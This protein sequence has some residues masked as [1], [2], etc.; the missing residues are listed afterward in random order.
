MAQGEIVVQHHHWLPHYFLEI[1][2][3]SFCWILI[4][5]PLNVFILS[6]IRSDRHNENFLLDLT[7]CH[8]IIQKKIYC[9]GIRGN[10][11]VCNSKI[12]VKKKLFD[13]LQLEQYASNTQNIS[14]ICLFFS[15][16]ATKH[17][18]VCSLFFL[19]SNISPFLWIYEFP[20][21]K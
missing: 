17:K 19:I 7:I 9:F 11:T 12:L 6:L 8:S 10:K 16:V 2:L 5:L 21:R 1:R 20:K 3:F 4:H 14:F 13:Q 18:I 15:A